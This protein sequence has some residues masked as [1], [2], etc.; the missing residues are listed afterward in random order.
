MLGFGKKAPSNLDWISTAPA[1]HIRAI[2]LALCDNEDVRER[3]TEGWK[4]IKSSNRGD[5][6]NMSICIQCS[7]PFRETDN[8]HGN[9][10][11][12]PEPLEIDPES[13]EWNDWDERCHGPIDYPRNETTYPGGYTYPCC[14]EDGTSPGC[15]TGKHEAHP[16]LSLKGKGGSRDPSVTSS[17]DSEDYEDF[18]DNDKDDRAEKDNSARDKAEVP[19]ARKGVKR[20]AEGSVTS[21]SVCSQCHETFVINNN[22]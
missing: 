16:D 21:R 15:K 6:D 1:Q 11:Y 7:Q 9:C 8:Q 12:H 17:M 22:K 13:G 19:A 20:K 14:D 5:D 18:Y 10:R 2:L 3:T 4:S